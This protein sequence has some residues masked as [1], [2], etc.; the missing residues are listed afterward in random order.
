MNEAEFQRLLSKARQVNWEDVS[1][2]MEDP[3]LTEEQHAQLRR[4]M[5]N[6]YRNEEYRNG[7][8]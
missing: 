8:L 7:N 5:L 1:V 3:A 6:K 4:V 2:M